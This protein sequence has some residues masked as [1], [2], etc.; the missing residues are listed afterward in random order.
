MKDPERQLLRFES[1]KQ[2]WLYFGW[3]ARTYIVFES[4]VIENNLITSGG[5]YAASSI[6]GNIPLYDGI[7]RLKV[8]WNQST[9]TRAFVDLDACPSCGCIV[10]YQSIPHEDGAL[11][12]LESSRAIDRPIYENT[13]W[14]LSWAGCDLLWLANSLELAYTFLGLGHT[15]KSF[16][17]NP[18]CA[19]QLPDYST[20]RLRC[21]GGMGVRVA[22][23]LRIEYV[24][25]GKESE[26]SASVKIS[27][28]V[29]ESRV[30]E[31]NIWRHLIDCTAK[32]FGMVFC[33]G[34]VCEIRNSHCCLDVH[35]SSIKSGIIV[36]EPRACH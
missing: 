27:N 15:A 2:T 12:E 32:W 5:C 19:W 6:R 18:Q 28:V 26:D 3:K 31:R 17:V 25:A 23:N 13:F 9:T 4:N 11:Q 35:C 1:V 14:E 34:D 10:G 33:Y 24:T 30:P 36:L 16:R 8:G 29:V 21:R 20:P 7:Y 22:N